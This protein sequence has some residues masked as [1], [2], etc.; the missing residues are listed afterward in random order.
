[1]LLCATTVILLASSAAEGPRLNAMEASMGA[2]ASWEAYSDALR[3]PFFFGG[4]LV[5]V[6]LS[7][8]WGLD[9]SYEVEKREER[10]PSHAAGVTGHLSLGPSLELSLSLIGSPPGRS[11]EGTYCLPL[12][13]EECVDAVERVSFF[14]PALVAEFSTDPERNV[15]GSLAAR[16]EAIFYRLQ[17]DFTSDSQGAEP[18]PIPVH[19]YRLGLEG[20]VGVYD[21]VELGAR[22]SYGFVSG[23]AKPGAISGGQ[24][25][26]TELPLAPTRFDVGPSL[27]VQVSP[28]L[29]ADLSAEYA[30]YI[31]ECFGHSLLGTARLTVL[32]GRLR[33]FGEVAYGRDVSPTDEATLQACEQDEPYPDYVSTAVSTGVRVEF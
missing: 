31:Y 5:E 20:V 13:E 9:L 24:L 22:G 17:Y 7:D 30:P 27:S 11:A 23:A 8:A 12:P 29:R 28:A 15:V 25:P 6:Q 16:A 14:S 26:P 3:V 32:P 2:G 18:L 1:M 10:G 19:E 4:G 33:L 21:R